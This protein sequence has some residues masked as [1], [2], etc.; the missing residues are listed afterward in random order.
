[1]EVRLNDVID[2]IEQMQDNEEAW[3]DPRS[4]QIV[5]DHPDDVEMERFIRLPDKYDRNDYHN[6]KLFIA[7]LDDE[8]EKD[9][10]YNAITGQGAFRRFRAACD[11][12]HILNDW[13]D[14]EDACHRDLAIDWCEAHGIVYR[15]DRDNDDEDEEDDD[16]SDFLQEDYS[17]PVQEPEEEPAPFVPFHIVALQEKNLENALVLYD[18]YRHEVLHL[19]S[20]LQAAEEDLYHVLSAGEHAYA[21]S[22]HGRLIGLAIV[23]NTADALVLHDLYVIKDMRRNGVG[24]LLVSQVK[25]LAKEADKPCLLYVPAISSASASFFLHEGWQLTKRVEMYLE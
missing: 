25:Q 6:M 2:A 24:H 3:Y 14:F 13:Y 18:D 17:E 7:G 8:G 15:L 9:W 20:D 19:P 1:M 16:V 21:V 4:Q 23:E 10:L 22:D 5:F 11:K 12:F